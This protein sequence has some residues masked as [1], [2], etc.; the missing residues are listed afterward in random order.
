MAVVV[1]ELVQVILVLLGARD[2]AGKWQHLDLFIHC[3][4][5]NIMSSRRCEGLGSICL[6]LG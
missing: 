1:G 3:S 4:I 2:V 6:N 5:G